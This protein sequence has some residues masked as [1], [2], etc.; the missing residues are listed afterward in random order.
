MQKF[1]PGIGPLG[2]SAG[3]VEPTARPVMQASVLF[4]AGDGRMA[5]Q[6]MLVG[7][8]GTSTWEMVCTTALQWASQVSEGAVRGRLGVVVARGTHRR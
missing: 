1:A 3:A 5:V 8:A 4:G 6:R 7:R 2:V